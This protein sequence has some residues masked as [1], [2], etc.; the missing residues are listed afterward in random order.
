MSDFV[1]GYYKP[2]LFMIS[3]RWFVLEGYVSSNSSMT[4]SA[5]NHAAE[6]YVKGLNTKLTCPLGT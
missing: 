3:G 6:E 4:R 1:A 2:H 5:Q